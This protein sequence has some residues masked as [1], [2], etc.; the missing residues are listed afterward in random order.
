MVKDEGS[1]SANALLFPAGERIVVT[2]AGSGIGRATAIRAAEVGLHVSAWDLDGASAEATAA[3]IVDAGGQAGAVTADVTD[4]EQVAAGFAALGG[5]ATYLV[6]NAGPASAGS[7]DFDT[8]VSMAAGS[9]HL[10]T[11]VWMRQELPEGAALV[12]LASVAGNFIGADPDWYSA[13]KAAIAGYTRH[14]AVRHAGRFRANAVAPGMIA[15]PR[16]AGFAGSEAL[17]SALARNPLGRM[18]EPDEVAWAILFLLSPMA[19]YINGVLL[20]IDG[21]WTVVH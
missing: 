9:V 15:T 17:V 16:S 18:G 2:G 10:V 8:G 1:G 21:G 11:E 6:N 19:A 3:H 5:P 20:P 4:G 14:L 13:A 12:N 7:R